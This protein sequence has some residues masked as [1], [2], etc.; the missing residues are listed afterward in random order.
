MNVN[1]LTPDEL[2]PKAPSCN[3]L[4]NTRLEL[5][6]RL[7]KL[8]STADPQSVRPRTL[9]H[10]AISN[11]WPLRYRLLYVRSHVTEAAR[12][13]YLLEFRDWDSFVRKFRATFVR[14]LRKAD[15]WRELEMRVQEPNE[16]TIDYFYA[17]IG[18]CHSLDLTFADTR[19]SVL[20]GLRSQPLTDWVYG[21]THSNRDDLLSDIRDWERIRAK[22][23]E[24]FETA[25]STST[26]PRHDMLSKNSPLNYGARNR[27]TL[28]PLFRRKRRPIHRTRLPKCR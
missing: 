15:L 25:N 17:K 2:A 12:S 22:R 13:W 16:P 6:E 1:T 23:K 3:E 7:Q 27:H 8:E 4:V 26:E 20:E 14:T 9:S 18:L 28:C 5:T 19:E 10:N 24:K 21:R 11:Q